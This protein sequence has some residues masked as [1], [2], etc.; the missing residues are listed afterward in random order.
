VRQRFTVQR[1]Y[2]TVFVACVAAFVPS[3]A[4]A[5]A[6]GVSL[7]WRAPPGCPAGE[8]V[9][10]RVLA[11]AEPGAAI[12]GEAEVTEIQGEF[13]IVVRVRLGDGTGERVLSAPSC[14][15]AAE[16]VAVVLAMSGTSPP[17]GAPPLTSPALPLP[18]PPPLPPPPR[19][20]PA[21]R[22]LFRLTPEAAFDA[23]TLPNPDFGVAVRVSVVPK[24]GLAFGVAGTV[25]LDQTGYVPNGSQGAAFG[26]LSF[27][28][29]GCQAWLRRRSI[30]LSACALV[31]LGRIA[32]SATGAIVDGSATAY[33][34]SLGLGVRGRLELTRWLG[35]ALELDGLVPTPRQSFSISDDGEKKTVRATSVVVAHAEFGPEVRF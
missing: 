17:A 1:S 35:L 2:L 24:E 31:E 27:D 6:S 7:R 14:D 9:R 34:I 10:R 32:A 23:G 19:S 15:A 20:T 4:K 13:H 28:A 33:G 21:A 5:D 16:S 25:W 8:S 30:E 22:S 3:R 11:L 12:D 26:F 18:L 29:F